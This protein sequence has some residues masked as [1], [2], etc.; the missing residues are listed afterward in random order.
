[1]AINTKKVWVGGI[2]AGVVLTV[3]DFVTNGLIFADQNAAALN[4]L[5]PDLAANVEGAGPAVAFVILDLLFG[6]VLVWT[7][8]AMRP[9]FG[10]GARTAM[11]AGLQIWLVVLLMYLGMTIMG[12]WSWGYMIT[13]AIIY[14]V[15]MLVAAYVGGMLYKEA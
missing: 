8:A 12:M 11:L 7:Y 5:N 3:I 13:G 1:M 2:V 6:V 10:A 9:R 4:A 14:L 15:S